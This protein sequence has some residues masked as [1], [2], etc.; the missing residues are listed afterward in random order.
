MNNNGYFPLNDAE[1]E[2]MLQSS[3]PNTPPEEVV[4]AVT[5][6]KKAI[7]R[8]LWGLGLSTLTLNFFGLN[9]ILPTI[10]IVLS[11]LGVRALR[12]E[13]KWFKVYYITTIVRAI[14]LLIVLV[15]G[16]TVSFRTLIP[17][18]VYIILNLSL[19]FLNIAFFCAA[20][21]SVE[22]KS[23]INPRTAPMA[24]LV[25][26]YL[27]I[28]FLSIINFNGFIVPWVMIIGFICIIVSLNKISKE[29]DQVGYNI[30]NAPVKIPD[31]ILTAILSVT[32]I[33]GLGCGYAFGGSYPMQ[34]EEKN[35]NEHIEVLQIKEHLIVLGFPEKILND[36]SA[37]DI[38]ACEGAT[39]IVVYEDKVP[40]NDDTR[41]ITVTEQVT[42]YFS[43]T[44]DKTIHDVEEMTVTGIGVCLTEESEG[45]GDWII[46]HHFCWDV[47]PGFYGTESIQL[48]P[49][50][51]TNTRNRFRYVDEPTGRV[52]YTKDDV[53]YVSD[54]YSLGSENY[55]SNTIFWG[56]QTNRDVFATFSLPDKGERQRG[57]VMYPVADNSD[58]NTIIDS[59][60]NYTHQESLLQYP[61]ITAKE[62]RQ[63]GTANKSFPFRTQQRA[64]QIRERE[65]N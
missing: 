57:Y 61:A 63:R 11:I 36:M 33:I 40:F 12:N 64:L 45:D 6:W 38:L 55:T 3:L 31:K 15:L 14:H 59:W 35:Q 51:Q 62:H 42:P 53:D 22:K 47:N 32:L 56:E 17:D 39:K 25:L 34:W 21:F 23:G 1:F 44:Y 41:V 28:S 20:L 24:A 5:P 10:G 48:W 18:T 37:E 49:A 26:W 16:T 58:T 43:S 60:F 8:I 54:Y 50:Y 13:T 9:H 46:I 29:I 65:L 30:E 2:D 27:G 4:E 7:R 52:L 19:T